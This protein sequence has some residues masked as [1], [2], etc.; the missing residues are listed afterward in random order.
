MNFERYDLLLPDDAIEESLMLEVEGENPLE[1]PAGQYVFIESYCAQ[2]DCDCCLVILHVYHLASDKLMAMLRYG[3]RD[4]AFYQE[5]LREE[6]KTPAV[7]SGVG[8]VDDSMDN[9]ASRALL[10][11]FET[12]VQNKTGYVN[13]L[14]AHYYQFKE[15]IL[16]RHIEQGLVSEPTR[17]V[18]T[19]QDSPCPCGSGLPY[20]RCCLS[21]TKH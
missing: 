1:I 16:L 8:L 9:P 14:Q 19:G 21:S 7:L 10:R 3:W 4:V 2:P 18:F 12:V 5:Q 15:A 13:Q 17:T 20:Q 6:T 11:L